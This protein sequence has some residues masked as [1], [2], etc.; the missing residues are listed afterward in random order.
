MPLTL[1]T[2]SI[3]ELSRC[4][5]ADRGEGIKELLEDAQLGLEGC[6]P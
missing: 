6:Q 5:G 3:S 4:L 2:L 1:L